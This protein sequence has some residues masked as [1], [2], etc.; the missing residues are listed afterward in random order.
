MIGVP[1]Y[2]DAREVYGLERVTNFSE[3]TSD[4]TVYTLLSE[5]YGNDV[6]Q[7][8]AFVGALAEEQTGTEL[9][10]GP[11]LRVRN[12]RERERRGGGT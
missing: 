3:I 6:S 10:F 8:D 12:K 5:A 9:F 7:L 11:L 2:N 1:T 4:E